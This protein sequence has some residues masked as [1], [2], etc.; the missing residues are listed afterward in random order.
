[1]AQYIGDNHILGAAT[2]LVA[3]TGAQAADLPVKAKPVEYVKVCS[4][5][6]AGFFYVPGTDTCLKIGMYIR[7]QHAYGNA[8]NINSTIQTAGSNN[9]GQDYYTYQ[10]RIM[11]TTDWRTQSDYGVIRAY[12]A[13]LANQGTNDQS[14]NSPNAFT[15]TGLGG[16]LR[17]F[18]QFAG[19]TVGHSVSTFDFTAYNN[20]GYLA[21]LFASSGVNGIDL[22]AY[23][24]QLGNGVSVSVDLE[25]GKNA[26]SNNLVNVNVA[27]IGAGGAFGST[28]GLNN[29]SSRAWTPDFAGNIRIDQAWGA[30]QI[31][32]AL[33]NNMSGEILGSTNQTAVGPDNWGYAI[34]GG[35][36]LN[37]FLMPKDTIEGAVVYAK[38]ALGYALGNPAQQQFG[39]G[40]SVALGWAPDV[41]FNAAGQSE[42]TEAWTVS[43]AYEHN[44]NN[45]WRTSVFGG[46]TQVNFNGNATAMLCAAPA[47][48]NASASAFSN[49]SPNFSQS[50]LSTR[51]A[52]NPH[53]TLEI[54]L[55]LL[56]VHN[57]TAN[58]GT[59]TLAATATGRQA[60]TYVVEDQDKYMAILRV[61][62]TILP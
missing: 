26:R 5:Y 59:A 22:I 29:N 39:A 30:A 58:A 60:G 38:G 32:G 9:R 16:L 54:G 37:N 35:I 27:S 55:D 23:T 56:W 53:P 46:V 6:G 36:R 25:D 45:Q 12:A 13:I 15:S 14:P 62:K 19:F 47:T 10:S 18:I 34:Q 44:W 57:D 11:L 24:W 51:T 7:S 33:H 1:M 61:I 43:G 31:S 2:G 4:L 40:N 42:L 49:C 21:P 52:W 48:Y 50:Q 3:M 17:V 20:Y 41:V 8:G 28:A